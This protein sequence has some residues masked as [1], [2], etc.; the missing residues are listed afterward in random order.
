MRRAIV[1]LL[2]L[3]LLAPP[4][5]ATAADKNGGSTPAPAPA[6]SPPSNPGL[7]G[8]APSG[9]VPPTPAP[10]PAPAPAP[11]NG[12]A[13]PNRS[14]SGLSGAATTGLVLGSIAILVVIGFF[15]ARDAR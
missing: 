11:S 12:S 8:P 4:G 7:F 1:L 6:P 5:V 3:V 9:G 15:I 14:N 10:A 13:P 2:S